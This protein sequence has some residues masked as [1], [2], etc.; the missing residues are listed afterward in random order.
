MMALSREMTDQ[1]IM[2]RCVE[3]SRIAVDKGEYPF[4]AII[5][6]DGKIV[7]E[8][9]N[10]NAPTVVSERVMVDLEQINRRRARPQIIGSN[11]D[12]GTLS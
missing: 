4:A 2:A 1:E 9:I 12:Q 10:R 5:A 3:L 7:A 6:S 8:A 11:S